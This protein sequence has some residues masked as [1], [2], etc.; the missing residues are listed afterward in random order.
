MAEGE[1]RW[2]SLLNP[3]KLKLAWQTPVGLDQGAA[4][5]PMTRYTLS[6]PCR[7]KAKAER[8]TEVGGIFHASSSRRIQKGYSGHQ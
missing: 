5:C 2:Q 3:C 1:S 4:G 6:T 7:T 8:L